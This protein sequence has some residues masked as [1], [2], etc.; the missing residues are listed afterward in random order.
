MATSCAAAPAGL[1][2]DERREG[3]QR[4]PE[5]AGADGGPVL[6]RPLLAA[7]ENGRDGEGE[8]PDPD[9]E[10]SSGEEQVHAAPLDEEADRRED[11]DEGGHD[12]HGRVERD[13]RIR[14]RIAVEAP[15]QG[16]QHR[17]QREHA[18]EQELTD[19]P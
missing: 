6:G 1:P 17:S 11:C 19:Q 18:G 10:E 2:R 15:C 12:R 5:E 3:D 9:R 7:R 16:E 14:E 4:R 13:A 8:G